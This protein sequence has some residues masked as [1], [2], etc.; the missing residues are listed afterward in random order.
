LPLATKYK[1]F[2]VAGFKAALIEFKL[3]SDIGEGGSPFLV[4]VL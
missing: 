1:A 2:V 4:Y 3:G